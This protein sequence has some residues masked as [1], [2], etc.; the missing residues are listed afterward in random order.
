MKKVTNK[1]IFTG[2]LA[3]AFVACLLVYVMVFT[4]YN[5]KTEALQASNKALQAQVSE[6]EVYYT[7]M[8]TYITD[9]KKMV[10]EIEKLTEDYTSQA[11]EE[12]FIMTAVD[13]QKESIINFDTVNIEAEE[14]IHTVP[15]EVVAASGLEQYQEQIEFYERR[16]SYGNSTDYANLKYA[17]QVI[18]D[19]DYRV[20]IDTISYKRDKEDNNFINGTIDITYYTIS[21]MNKPYEYPSMDSYLSG[22]Q[23]LFAKMYYQEGEEKPADE[24]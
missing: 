17:L 11:N 24:E 2:V 8:Q 21:G 16:A 9:T 20:G 18:F 6:L 19:N 22:V 23:D 4:K 10:A 5:D 3:V 15:Q 13:M 14:V 1:S 12:D 7:N